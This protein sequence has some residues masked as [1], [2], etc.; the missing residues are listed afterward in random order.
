MCV[1]V[2]VCLCRI[3]LSPAPR[4]SPQEGGGIYVVYSGN[5]TVSTGSAF[6]GNSAKKVCLVTPG[7]PN[8]R[9]NPGPVLTQWGPAIRHNRTTPEKTTNITSTRT[10]FLMQKRPVCYVFHSTVVICE[11]METRC[12]LDSNL[13]DLWII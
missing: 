7:R 10:L 3:T 12:L 11:A 2:R 1:R 9:R 6:Y 8:Q 13:A 4:P 5:V